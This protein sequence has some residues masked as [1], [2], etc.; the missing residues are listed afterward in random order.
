MPS[1]LSLPEHLASFSTPLCQSSQTLMQKI[2][3]P[4]SVWSALEAFLGPKDGLDERRCIV[5]RNYATLYFVFAIDDA[6]SELGI[7]DLTQVFVEGLGQHFENAC[8]LDLG[9]YFDEAHHILAEII[10]GSIALEA[11]GDEISNS[12][13]FEGQKELI[14]IGK[15]FIFGTPLGWLTDELAGIT[16]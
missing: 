8:E 9:F 1:I 12:A 15:S 16:T 5:C 4:I 3:S 11:N 14:C 10:Q 7:L 6:E 13:S 2:F